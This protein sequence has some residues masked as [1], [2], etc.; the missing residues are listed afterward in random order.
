MED[1]CW[2]IFKVEALL[3]GFLILALQLWGALFNIIFMEI[4]AQR[5]YVDIY[6]VM[7]ITVS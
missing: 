7:D 4:R 3:V 6:R 1:V 2:G 5:G